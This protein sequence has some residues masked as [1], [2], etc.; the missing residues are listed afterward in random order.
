MISQPSV[1][2]SLLP[3]GDHIFYTQNRKSSITTNNVSHF[4]HGLLD[5]NENSIVL[6][7]LVKNNTKRKTLLRLCFTF[8]LGILSVSL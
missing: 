2:S 8:G 3:N 6:N 1:V 4:I 7:I 5:E